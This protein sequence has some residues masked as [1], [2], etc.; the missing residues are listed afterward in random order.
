MN[1]K[2]YLKGALVFDCPYTDAYGDDGHEDEWNEDED[3]EDLTTLQFVA[4]EQLKHEQHQVHTRADYHR[5]VLHVGI[6]LHP[7]KKD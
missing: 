3:P 1:D 4:G 2:P 7:T 5:L 6:T